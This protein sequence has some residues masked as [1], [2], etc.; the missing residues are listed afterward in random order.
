MTSQVLINP[1]PTPSEVVWADTTDFSVTGVTR[2]DQI[3][4]TGLSSGAFRQGAKADLGSLPADQYVLEIAVEYGASAPTAGSTVEVYLA[5]SDNAT[6]A[7]L[8]PAGTSGSDAAYTGYSSDASDAIKQAELVGVMPLSAVGAGTVQRMVLGL[9][10]TKKRYVNPVIR[11]RGA[12][13]MD[14]DAINMY[15]KMTPRV[16]ESQ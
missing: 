11:N 10:D 6:A 13:T 3:D 5:W 1:S 4:L 9:V 7:T 16:L 14:T 15:L 12:Q 8:N 2:T